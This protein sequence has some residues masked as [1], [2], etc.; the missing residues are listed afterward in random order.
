M[1]K[2]PDDYPPWEEFYAIVA[3]HGSNVTPYD[4]LL[5]QE[6]RTF[7]LIRDGNIAVLLT[8]DTDYNLE[9]QTLDLTDI[10][11]APEPP[12]SPAEFEILSIYPNPFNSYVI[13]NLFAR[14]P[15]TT[16]VNL[17]NTIGQSVY[18]DKIK[19]SSGLNTVHL[20]E[21]QLCSSQY[22]LVVK[23]KL[24][25]QTKNVIFLK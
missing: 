4:L 17:I 12:I 24:M 13:V 15:M 16:E 23:S 8:L 14:N 5:D 21:L 19:L 25:N 11:A 10:N 7:E 20:S 9:I 18:Y 3:Q 1:G 2:N 6:L 22:T